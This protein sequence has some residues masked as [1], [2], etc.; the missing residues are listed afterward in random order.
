MHV[1]DPTKAA[2]VPAAHTKHWFDDVWA[3]ADTE[4][5]VKYLPTAQLKQSAT[6]S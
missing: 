1:L 5:S 4:L 3:D 2:K 6:E